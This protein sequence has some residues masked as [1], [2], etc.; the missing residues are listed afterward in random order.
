[1][2]VTNFNVGLRI[3]G[4][5]MYTPEE[6]NDFVTLC[7]VLYGS[8]Q[9]GRSDSKIRISFNVFFEFVAFS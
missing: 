3:Q 5:G 8:D 6:D 9:T 1:M 7:K 4:S 2:V